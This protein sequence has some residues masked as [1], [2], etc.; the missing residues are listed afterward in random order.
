MGRTKRVC[1]LQQLKSILALNMQFK[2]E[3]WGKLETSGLGP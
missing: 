3:L 2:S 1:E